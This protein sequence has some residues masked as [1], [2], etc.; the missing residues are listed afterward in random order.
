MFFQIASLFPNHFSYPRKANFLIPKKEG[1]RKIRAGYFSF[2]PHPLAFKQL[3]LPASIILRVS[4]C[5]RAILH[6]H[7]SPANRFR[8]IVNNVIKLSGRGCIVAI[9]RFIERG[10]EVL[11]IIDVHSNRSSSFH[12]RRC[13][14]ETIPI[15]WFQCDTLL[16]VTCLIM[17]DGRGRSLDGYLEILM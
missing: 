3:F 1:K 6:F 17:E 7:C 16:S 15:S 9:I 11:P 2:A 8:S 10:E 12:I 5:S 13:P 4:G 14:R